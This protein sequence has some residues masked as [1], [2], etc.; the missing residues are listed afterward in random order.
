MLESIRFVAAVA[1]AGASIMIGQALS[2]PVE[3]TPLQLEAKIPLGDVRGRIDHMAIDLVRQRLIVAELGND[4]VSLVD[5]KDR[6]VLRRISGLKEPQGV[7]YVPS[8]D[9]LYVANAGDGSLRLF[10]G[11]NYAEEA[12]ISLGDDADNIRV[13]AAA[14]RVIVGHGSGALAM[15]DAATRT[16]IADI[17][18]KGH[19]ESFQLTRDGREIFVN[20]PNAREIAVID[21]G[22]AKQVGS[23][24]MRSA[25]GN[26]PMAL[27]EDTG[28]LFTVFRYPAKL[29]VFALPDGKLIAA[30]D[31][32]RDADDVFVDAKRQ[33][34]Y[35][36]CG[37][38]SLDVVDAQGAFRRIARI[39]TVAGART[40]L[41]AP[42]L[43]RLFL[44]IRAERAEAASIWI[45]R[46]VP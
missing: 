9:S 31:T 14:H 42:D 30:P 16:K 41:F 45:F 40:A 24:P 1:L 12:R 32:C 23:W 3:T 44:A 39:P 4:S 27:D 11:E 6:K 18:L 38:G 46:P 28:R 36:S 22:A 35:A 43:D 33:R 7:G 2:Q 34:L 8:T 21:R 26:F 10:Q 19:P 29:G 20:V 13:D 17:P 25:T 15:I 37:D 5:L